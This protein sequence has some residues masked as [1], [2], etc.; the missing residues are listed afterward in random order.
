MIDI[1]LSKEQIDLRARYR[2]LVAKEIVPHVKEIDEKDVIPRELVKALVSPPFNLTALSVP[3][4]YGGQEMGILDVC[5]ISEEI[6]HGCPALIPFLEI[7]QLYS[8]VINIGGTEEQKERF[9]GALAKG[10]IGC[11]ALTDE[12]SGSDPAGM[13]TRAEKEGNDYVLK[14]RKRII[15]FADMAD[16]FAIFAKTGPEGNT[17]NISA[18]IF[19]KGTP[20]FK[21]DGHCEAMGLK[22]HRAYNLLFEGAKIPEANR[23]GLEGDGLKIAL[24]VLANT[25]ISLSFGFVGLARAALECAIDFAKTRIIGG[26]PIA[27]NQGIAFP[28]ADIATEIDA[29]RLLAFRAAKMEEKKVDHR[30]ETSMAKYYSGNVL[31]KAVD[32]AN[33]VLAGYGSDTSYPAER[34]LRDAYTWIAAQGTS[35][36][37]KLVISRDLLKSDSSDAPKSTPKGKKKQ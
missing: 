29:A 23:I 26:K 21:L 2:D 20:G 17:R 1:F 36:V 37:Q 28:I 14:G 12:G 30:K 35:E 13:K 5:L 16:L 4:R 31:I 6:G 34:Y 10:K 24:S 15:T 3:K 8:Y 19:E 27:E 9:L 18:F 25:R 33:R 11:Y 22:G 7:A 32:L